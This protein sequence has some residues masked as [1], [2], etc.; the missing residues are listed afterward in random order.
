[1]THL[2]INFLAN[3]SQI[4]SPQV[5]IMTYSN[6]PIVYP[7]RITLVVLHADRTGYHPTNL[8]SY[9]YHSVLRQKEKER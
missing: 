8:F 6:L 9:S 4:I 3:I 5:A 7:T 1:M 2:I